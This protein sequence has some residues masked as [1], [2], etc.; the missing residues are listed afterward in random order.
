MSREVE[1]HRLRLVR[2]ALRIAFAHDRLRAGFVQRCDKDGVAVGRA[3][4]HQPLPRAAAKPGDGQPGQYLGKGRDVGLRIAGTHPQRV[5]FHDLARQ[6]FVEPRRLPPP[7]RADAVGHRTVG[8]ETLRL[9]EIEQH[10][11]MPHR[12]DQEIR[13]FAHDV[14]A[15]R[16]ELVIAGKTDHRQLVGRHG[17]MVGP[18]VDEPFGEGRWRRDRI[19]KPRGGRIDI[20]GA[21]CGARQALQFGGHRRA[22]AVLLGDIIRRIA[23]HRSPVVLI[24]DIG[25]G[26][27]G[28][29]G[30]G[31][32]RCGGRVIAGQLMQQ[33]RLRVVGREIVEA[34][35]EAEA[36]G[37]KIKAGHR[38]SFGF[39]PRSCPSFV[40]KSCQQN[41]GPPRQDSGLS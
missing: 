38:A 8:P 30:Q 34:A 27:G 35:A 20:M 28:A 33:P 31:G 22:C 2:A 17:E 10:G 37:G 23:A 41:G 26:D 21:D 12:R 11:G 40:A 6:I 3:R 9:I 25:G 29:A 39:R 19:G 18:E 36:V 5:Q 4:R 16:L 24:F 7:A 15:D 14:G 1:Q 32:D 13:K